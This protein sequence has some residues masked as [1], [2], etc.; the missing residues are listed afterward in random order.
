MYHFISLTSFEIKN[1]IKFRY[2]LKTVYYNF[3]LITVLVPYFHSLKKLIPLFKII[4]FW[5][6]HQIFIHKSGDRIY[7]K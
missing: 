5:S 2:K 3:C 6:F 4:Q 1:N 7:F